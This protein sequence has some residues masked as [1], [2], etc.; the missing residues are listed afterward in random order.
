MGELTKLQAFIKKIR[1]WLGKKIDP[2]IYSWN[3]Y[4]TSAIHDLNCTI[5][6]LRIESGKFWRCDICGELRHFTEEKVGV[7]C[8]I[9]ADCAE[10][11]KREYA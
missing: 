7:D 6:D 11:S 1:E 9:C 5:D 3:D 2:E 8:D 10:E 4:L